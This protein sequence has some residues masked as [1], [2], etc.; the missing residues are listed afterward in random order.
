MISA[1]QDT[2][3]SKEN[4]GKIYA[5]YKI[6]YFAAKTQHVYDASQIIYWM[7]LNVFLHSVIF[8]FV[9]SVKLDQFFVIYVLKVMSIMCGLRC[10]RKWKE[11][12]SL[13]IV[14]LCLKLVEYLSAK[15]VGKDIDL[16]IKI[17]FIVL[18]IALWTAKLVLPIMILSLTAHNVS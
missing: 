8:H 4:A 18:E 13:W 7:V 10:V 16:R 11:N 9:I 1:V 3:N 14:W 6:V 12:L 17:K 2:Q 15:N 5:I